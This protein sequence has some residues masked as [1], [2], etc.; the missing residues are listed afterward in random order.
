MDGWQ[1]TSLKGAD[2]FSASKATEG[3]EWFT[4]DSAGGQC[5]TFED[6]PNID[7][8]CATCVSGEDECEPAEP[9]PS[10]NATTPQLGMTIHAED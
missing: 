9:L 8:S 6:C 1:E 3:C 4:H 5:Y 10:S 7:E 2:A